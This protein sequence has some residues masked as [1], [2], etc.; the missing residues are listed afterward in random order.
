MQTRS[1][2]PTKNTDAFNP[3]CE[4]LDESVQSGVVAGGSVMVVQGDEI[5]LQ[6]GFGYTDLESKAPFRVDTPVAI[7]S[8]S[9]PMVGTTLYCLAESGKL[10]LA[11]PVSEYLPEFTDLKLESGAAVKQAPSVAEL[12]THTSGLRASEA[13]GGRIWLQDWTYDKTLEYVVGKV[14]REIP[15]KSQ[16]GT[17][18]AY[19]GI[20]TEVAARVGEIASGLPRNEMLETYLCTPLAMRMTFYRAQDQ[21]ERLRWPLPTRYHLSKKTGEL[22]ESARRPIPKANGYCSSGGSIVS[23]A[24]D[25]LNWLLMIRDNGIHD[26]EAFLA[27]ECVT[28]MLRPHAFG[29]KA[30]GGLGVVSRDESGKPVVYRHGGSTG[31][32]VWIDFERDLIGIMLTQ[33]KSSDIQPFRLELERRISVAVPHPR[34]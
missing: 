4:Y 13:P 24:P 27:P 33:T 6:T 10:D 11:V 9:K 3:V 2:L 7:A 8:I 5:V 31:T 25:L 12:L 1:N 15:F 23:T 29:E 18:Y 16:P 28:A 34:A 26:G 17:E 19:S 14:A 20:G 30:S 22:V 21:M 32:S